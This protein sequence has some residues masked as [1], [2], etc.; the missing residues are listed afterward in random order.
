MNN[1]IFVL[2]KALTKSFLVTLLL[3]ATGSALA[4]TAPAGAPQKVA[5][6][7]MAAALFNS[8]KAKEIDKE[9]QVLI[10]DDQ[11]KINTLRDE[12]KAL[13]EKMQKDKAV[14]SEAEVRKSNERLQEISA[15][16]QLVVERVQKLVQE[17]R[18]Q[19]QEAYQ[20]NL[21]QAITQVIE[22][23][24]YD[25]VF[26]AGALLHYNTAYDITAKVTEKLNA[27]K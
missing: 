24:K 12:G 6:L 8:D 7:D 2:S 21:I 5:V 15:Q 27:Q 23:E 11:T 4:Q 3:T 1:P 16:Y 10:A 17:R 18:Q 25:M 19:F 22:A 26:Q 14:M 9:V 13:Q 20:Q